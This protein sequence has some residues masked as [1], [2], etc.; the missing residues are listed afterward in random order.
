M[1]YLRSMRKMK[2]KEGGGG[3]MV[4]WKRDK[5]TEVME[6]ETKGRAIMDVT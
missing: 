2:D 4:I 1:K 3:I 6:I 5:V